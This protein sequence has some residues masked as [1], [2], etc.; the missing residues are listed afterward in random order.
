MGLQYAVHTGLRSFWAPSG[1]GE[2]WSVTVLGGVEVRSPAKR[3]PSA[4]DLW[5]AR[6]SAWAGGDGLPQP[7]A[8]APEQLKTNKGGWGSPGVG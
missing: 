2:L 1:S 8:S 3:C 4:D 6:H 7:R 5:A